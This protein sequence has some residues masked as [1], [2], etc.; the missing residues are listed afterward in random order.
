MKPIL[1]DKI[2]Y[3]LICLITLTYKFLLF[4][5]IKV[6]RIGV[7]KLLKNLLSRNLTILLLS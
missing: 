7:V 3:R 1:D 2:A 4:C 6:L 5:F